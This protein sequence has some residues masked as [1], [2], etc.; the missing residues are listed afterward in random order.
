MFGRIQRRLGQRVRF[1]GL[2]VAA[3]GLTLLAAPCFALTPDALAASSVVLCVPSTA[4]QAITSAGSGGTC[5]SSQTPVA[6]PS[7]HAEQQTLLSILPDT[8]FK[9]NGVDGKPTIQFSGVNVQ[10]VSGSGSTSGAVNG[11]GNLIVGYAEDGAGHP[12]SGS[13]DLVVGVGNSWS[14]YGEIVGG[15]YNQVTGAG[16]VALGSG[17]TASGGASLAAGGNGNIASGPQSTVIGGAGN[18]ATGFGSSITGGVLNTAG[19]ED[20]SI[21]GGGVN[22]ASAE[23]SSIAGGEYNAATDED[24]SILGGCSNRTGT[25]PD[26]H[27][28]DCAGT[29]TGRRRARSQAA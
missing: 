10:V 13:N 14:G 19:G 9:A 8:E 23:N 7:S 16:A 3:F 12:Q 20:S 25:G 26:P 1:R 29:L 4:G 5:S 6:L 2:A 28:S 22:T 24:G 21:S 27:A 11:E 18:I 15:S 17:N